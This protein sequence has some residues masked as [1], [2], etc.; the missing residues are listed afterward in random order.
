MV[1]TAVPYQE[2]GAG[3]PLSTDAP[4]PPAAHWSTAHVAVKYCTGAC[5]LGAG[6]GDLIA[7]L[8]SAEIQA[9]GLTAV[10]IHSISITLKEQHSVHAELYHAHPTISIPSHNGIT[11]IMG[12]DESEARR[13]Q[14]REHA[15]TSALQCL[16]S[17]RPTQHED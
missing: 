17:E 10:C 2:G 14:V 9:S 11:W 16:Q 6:R 5:G 13:L 15:R 3:E 8:V 4:P 1:R 7:L 12:I